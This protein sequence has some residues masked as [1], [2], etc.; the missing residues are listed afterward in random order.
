MLITVNRNIYSKIKSSIPL[1]SSLIRSSAK[2]ID[3]GSTSITRRVALVTTAMLLLNNVA[4]TAISN[5]TN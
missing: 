4:P 3:Y 5:P 1:A 2:F